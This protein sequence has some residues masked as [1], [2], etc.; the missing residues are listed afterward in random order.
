M[1]L[2]WDLLDMLIPGEYAGLGPLRDQ[3]VLAT[4]SPHYHRHSL[5]VHKG[6]WLKK[7]FKH[8]TFNRKNHRDVNIAVEL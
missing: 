4:W 3:Q 8:G 7:F 6:P 5:P 2:Y 1:Y